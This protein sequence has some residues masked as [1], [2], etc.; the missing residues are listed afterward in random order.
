MSTIRPID[1]SSS[2]IC[3]YWFLLASPQIFIFFCLSKSGLVEANNAIDL[4]Y[5]YGGLSVLVC[6]FLFVIS[7]VKCSSRFS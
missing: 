4:D 3:F 2:R 6:Y 1:F 5:G 7:S